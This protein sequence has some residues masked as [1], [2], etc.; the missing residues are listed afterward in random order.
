MQL[1]KHTY[2]VKSKVKVSVWKGHYCESSSCQGEQI[3]PYIIIGTYNKN[4]FRWT[5]WELPISLVSH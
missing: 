2:A 1:Y 5:L 3:S 4:C